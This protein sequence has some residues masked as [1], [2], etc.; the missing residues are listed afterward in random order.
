ME[1]D[2]NRHLDRDCLTNSPPPSS[3][4]KE[5][6]TSSQSDLI[7]TKSTPS[8][9]PFFT[10]INDN[11]KRT[12]AEPLAGSTSSRFTR[13]EKRQKTLKDVAT[14]PLA[15]RFRPQSFPEFVG[16]GHIMGPDAL[17]MRLL[18]SESGCAGS[19]ILWGPSGCGKTTLARL[20]ATHTDAV[21]KELSATSSGTNDVRSVFEEGK[22]LLSLTG[23]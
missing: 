6:V 9:A 11:N 13:A 19:I 22:K 3:S 18:Q 1:Q 4:S 14:A 21:F 10:R 16:Q 12:I 7:S 20:L 2:I 23:R 5:Q 17:L 8:L 15:E